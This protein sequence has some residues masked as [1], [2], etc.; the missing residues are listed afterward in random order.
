MRASCS[1]RTFAFIKS[2]IQPLLLVV[3]LLAPV[4]TWPKTLY[5]PCNLL[6]LPQMQ[7]SMAAKGRMQD[8]PDTEPAREVLSRGKQAIPELITCLTDVRKTNRPVFQY[9][10]ETT[11]GDIA[12]VFLTDLFTD[13]TW[14]HSTVDGVPSWNQIQ[15]ESPEQPAEQAWRNYVAKHGTKH[16]QERWRKIWKG[17]ESRIYWD[18]SEKCFKLHQ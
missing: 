1:S 10:S 8:M 16:V 6:G 3:A 12:F 9:W 15:A 18:D 13:S 14:K 5:P 17:N 11:V 2:A 7:P 4:Q